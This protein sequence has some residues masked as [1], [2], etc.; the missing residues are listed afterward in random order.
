MNRKYYTDAEE[1]DADAM[2]KWWEEL[3]INTVVVGDSMFMGASVCVTGSDF[4]LCIGDE[5]DEPMPELFSQVLAAYFKEMGWKY[6]TRR[7]TYAMRHTD[8]TA[9][10]GL[11]PNIDL[12]LKLRFG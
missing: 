7:L 6:R 10:I 5:D 3:P 11:P 12:L 2:C 8:Y 9:F 4:D 1:R